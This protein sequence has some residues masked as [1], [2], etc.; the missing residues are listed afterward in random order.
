M[1]ES[2]SGTEDPPVAPSALGIEAARNLAHTAKSVPQMQGISSRWLLRIL[3]WVNVPGG[4]YRVNRRLA[5]TIGDGRVKF[6]NAGLRAHVI[7]KTLREIA[8]FRDF[9]AASI[10]DAL[11]DAFEQQEVEPGTVLARAASKGDRLVLIARGKVERIGA[12]NYTESVSHGV[13]AEGSYF[14]DQYLTGKGPW[15]FTYRAMTACTLLTLP[16]RA[17]RQL[18]STAPEL[19][20]HVDAYLSRPR[21]AMTRRGEADIAIASGHGGEAPVPSTFVDYEA[22]PRE[23]PLSIAQTVLRINTRVADLYN[24]PQD[25]TDQQLRL[26]IEALRERQEHEMVN[27]PDFGLLHNADPQQRISTRHGPPTPDDLDEL[28]SMRRQTTF[29]LAHRR[30]IAAFARECTRAKICPPGTEFHG[31]HVVAWRG[32]PFLPCNKIP[33]SANLTSSVLAL[34]TGEDNGG[35]IAL[36][37]TGLADEYEPGLSARFMGIDDRATLSYLVSTYYSV[38]VLLPSALG[39]LENAEVGHYNE[40]PDAL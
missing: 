2:I 25:Q 32:I 9:P 15:E 17:F 27:H 37:Q 34:R 21:P 39:I 16:R 14:G 6:D 4:T 29:L 5:Y 13:L 7:P 38:A 18:R 30:T 23:Y 35:V 19:G 1:P 10:L 40:P 8:L 3:P 20:A 26:T 11:S 28:I 22:S 24:G 31:H 36:H 12:G 33:I